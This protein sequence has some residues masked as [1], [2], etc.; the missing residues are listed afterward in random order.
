ML[1]CVPTV[2]AISWSIFSGLKSS[3]LTGVKNDRTTGE[4]GVNSS[5]PPGNGCFKVTSEGLGQ[6]QRVGHS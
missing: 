5:L 6:T 4:G 1:G 2:W 3:A